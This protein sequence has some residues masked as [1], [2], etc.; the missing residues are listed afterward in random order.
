MPIREILFES[1]DTG[2][3]FGYVYCV[4]EASDNIRDNFDNFPPILENFN[5]PSNDILP[6]L[7]EYS[8][9][10]PLFS[11]PRMLISTY[12]LKEGII[13]TPL[14]LFFS[15]LELV[16]RKNYRFVQY[17]PLNCNN[18]FVQSAAQARKAGHENPNSVLVAETMKLLTNS[19]Y[20]YQIRDR[21]RHTV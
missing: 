14:L 4:T 9:K 5:V 6:P 17:T 1:I 13:I 19:S 11:Q 10:E 8:E 3:L 12:F 16:C 7:K 2:R 21:S 20:G 15:D 18:G